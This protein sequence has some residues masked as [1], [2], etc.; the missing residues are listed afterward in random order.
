MVDHRD[1]RLNGGLGD[2]DSQM[3]SMEEMI[4]TVLGCV[5]TDTDQY[6]PTA[7]WSERGHEEKKSVTKS[8]R[9]N[10]KTHRTIRHRGHGQLPN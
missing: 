9:Q 1:C 8:V 2:W 3:L 5:Q 6:T 4:C 10:S 7:Q